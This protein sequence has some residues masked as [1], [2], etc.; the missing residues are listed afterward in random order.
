MRWKNLLYRWTDNTIWHQRLTGLS[1]FLYDTSHT[2]LVFFIKLFS[3]ILF[4]FS[5]HEAI[6]VFNFRWLDYQSRCITYFNYI[7]LCS[8]FVPFNIN[9]LTIPI[10]F[11][12]TLMTALF[13][14]CADWTNT[15]K[16]SIYFA[17][18]ELGI[19]LEL[20][21]DS[22]ILIVLI[23]KLRQN[24]I[25]FFENK[26]WYLIHIFI[27]IV[28]VDSL[29]IIEA[30]ER[31]FLLLFNLFNSL[32]NPLKLFWRQQDIYYAFEKFVLFR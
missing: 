15:N 23:T 27:F 7:T 32:F 25:F 20:H 28:T 2:P 31:T 14:L 26:I 9:I 4:S 8:L 24:N 5:E 10:L 18:V 11:F 3:N 29:I 22:P 19:I 30:I 6:I 16:R 1:C 13:F 12:I 17:H 21:S